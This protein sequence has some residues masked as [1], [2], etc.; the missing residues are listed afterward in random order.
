MCL[1]TVRRSQDLQ[2]GEKAWQMVAL[3]VLGINGTILEGRVNHEVRE[4]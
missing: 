1:A 3:K 4:L 2:T